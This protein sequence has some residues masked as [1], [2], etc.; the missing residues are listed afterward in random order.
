MK[1]L[2]E[3]AVGERATIVGFS[4]Q[5]VSQQRLQSLGLLP[6]TEIEVK[7]LAPLGDPVQIFLRGFSLG[8]RKSDADGLVV[9]S[10][11]DS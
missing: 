1:R 3:L 4:D 7:R 5:N 9:Q 11:R 2:G 10:I 8:I 6:G